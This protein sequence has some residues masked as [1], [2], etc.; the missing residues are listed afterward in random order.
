MP[1]QYDVFF[2]YKRDLE[3]DTWHQR[4]KEKMAYWLKQELRQP[5]VSIFFDTEDIKTG[6][7]WRTKLRTALSVSK[8]VVCIWSPL[9]FKSKWCVS[10]WVTFEK[11]GQ[12]YG[13]DLVIPARYFDGEHYPEPAKERQSRDF[14]KFACIMPRF[15]E[16]EH[17]V[18]FDLTQLRPFASDLAQI[19][20]AAPPFDPNFP[21]VE[22]SDDLLLG[23]TRIDRVGDA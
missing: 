13:V 16:T 10:E 23:D 12:N 18:E 3:S 7:R 8:C 1:Y 2:S 20:R 11:R 4:V 19:I 6:Q 9:Y 17:A 5:E 22:A 21:V 15:W 14:S